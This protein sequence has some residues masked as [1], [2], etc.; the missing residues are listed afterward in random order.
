MVA[1]QLPILREVPGPRG[2]VNC[3]DNLAFM[4]DIPSETMKLIVTSPPYN[5]GKAYEKRRSLD[6]YV[7]SQAQV[8]SECVR[9]LHPRGSICWQVGNHITSDGEVV[10]LDILL[11]PLF[12][13]HGLFL[14]NRIV[15]HF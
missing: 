7:S 10:P 3:E 4:R 2:F 5:I 15:W 12:K 13:D 1:E 8:I 14:R 9:L 6:T 11:Y